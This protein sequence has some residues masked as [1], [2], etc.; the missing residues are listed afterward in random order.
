MKKQK[1]AYPR[2]PNVLITSRK[3]ALPSDKHRFS[4]RS[5][6]GTIQRSGLIWRLYMS[7]SN[8]N[9]VV[10]VNTNRLWLLS[11]PLVVSESWAWV[12]GLRELPVEDDDGD[13]DD[14]VEDHRYTS[15]PLLR[16]S[17][18]LLAMLERIGSVWAIT[19]FELRSFRRWRWL[20]SAV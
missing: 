2:Q 16:A 7:F 6:E 8:K 3:K 12:N 18:P 1:T 13:G 19:F 15:D 5:A 10:K 17:L 4:P 11:T 9:A 20:S 14:D